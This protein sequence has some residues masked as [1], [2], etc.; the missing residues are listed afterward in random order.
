[1]GVELSR[2]PCPVGWGGAAPRR[3]RPARLRESLGLF[4]FAQGLR[5]FFAVCLR[6]EVLSAHSVDD[7]SVLPVRQTRTPS[8]SRPTLA[9][10]KPLPGPCHGSGWSF[11]A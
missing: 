4:V 10:T 6:L 1:M 7:E 3:V 11:P 5:Y 8:N 9:V 2:A